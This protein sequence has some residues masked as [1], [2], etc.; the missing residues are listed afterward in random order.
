MNSVHVKVFR[1]GFYGLVVLF[2]ALSCA[3]GVLRVSAHAN[4]VRSQ[5]AANPVFDG[6]PSEV[7]LWFSEVPE[8]T[9]S[10]I[11]LF[12]K[13]SNPASG[14]G[15]LHVDPSDNSLLLAQ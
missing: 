10:S 9:F 14:D 12:D 11:Q 15:A 3:I 6:P 5:P 1:R 4:L 2:L 8:P 13:L 7:K